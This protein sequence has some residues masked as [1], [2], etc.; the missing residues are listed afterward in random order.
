VPSRQ[1]E[2]K[3]KTYDKV[4]TD[5]FACL[6]NDIKTVYEKASANHPNFNIVSHQKASTL[7]INVIMLR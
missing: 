7:I 4:A 2:W 6:N 5:R 1:F 3:S